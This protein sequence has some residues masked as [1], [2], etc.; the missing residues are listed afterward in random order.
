MNASQLFT[1]RAYSFNCDLEID[2][3]EASYRFVSQV[4][5]KSELEIEI[6]K[7]SEIECNETRPGEQY[8]PGQVFPL[9][10]ALD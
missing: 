4:L 2:K 5:D 1:G 9:L 8:L 3:E 10:P 6:E 7:I